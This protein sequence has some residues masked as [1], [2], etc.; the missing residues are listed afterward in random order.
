MGIPDHEGGEYLVEAMFA[1]GPTRADGMGEG[2]TGYAEIEAFARAT[3]RLDEPWEIE[4]I[5][6][7]CVAYVEAREAGK[8]PLAREPGKGT[9]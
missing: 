9:T 8:H 5:R 6:A 7:M 1:L 3:G 2:P 4:A